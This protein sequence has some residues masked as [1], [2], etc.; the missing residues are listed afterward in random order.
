M[1]SPLLSR[2]GLPLAMLFCLAG[3]G[4]ALWP[5]R[6]VEPQFHNPF[7]QLHR[8][9]VLPFYN[10]STKPTVDGEQVA[11]AYYN[12]LQLISGFEVMPVGVAKRMLE[13]ATNATG[14]E[15]RSGADFQG[16]ARLMGVDAVIVR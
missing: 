9:A 16:L 15:P 7:P 1:K 13:A 12:E 4:C 2:L 3:S 11:I 10:Q 8:V 14:N 6:I 5:D